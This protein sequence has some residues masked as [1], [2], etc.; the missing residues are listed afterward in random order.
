MIERLW[1]QQIKDEERKMADTEEGEIFKI[2]V[3]IYTVYKDFQLN[4]NFK[5]CA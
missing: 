4:R 1:R 2:V 3:N 5:I